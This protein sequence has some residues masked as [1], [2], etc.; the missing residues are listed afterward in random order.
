MSELW[1]PDKV[2]ASAAMETL[3]VKSGCHQESAEC[4]I[5]GL[6]GGLYFG[7]RFVI[8]QGLSGSETLHVGTGERILSQV[9]GRELGSS[10]GAE[11]AQTPG[12][13]RS[14]LTCRSTA[15]RRQ[16]PRSAAQTEPGT[17]LGVPFVSGC[18][19]RA[20]FGLLDKTL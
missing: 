4:L 12:S 19:P 1:P 17:A 13:Q 20:H 15:A 18:L 10:K 6:T 9:L 16:G 7:D 11:V 3:A 2:G 5:R 14:H 8:L